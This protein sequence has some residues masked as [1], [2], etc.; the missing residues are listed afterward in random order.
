VFRPYGLCE[1]R[2][3]LPNFSGIIVNDVV[4]TCLA[5]RHGIA[6]RRNSVIDVN[7]RPNILPFANDGKAPPFH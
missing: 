3:P 7:K 5:S 4:D 1:N 6:G 2:K